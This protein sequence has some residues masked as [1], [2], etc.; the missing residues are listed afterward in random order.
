MYKEDT[1]SVE[2]HERDYIPSLRAMCQSNTVTIA[3]DGGFKKEGSVGSSAAVLLL[4]ASNN[5]GIQ[6][7]YN[8]EVEVG[9][10]N[11]RAELQAMIL[12]LELA[13]DYLRANEL[14]ETESINFILDSSYVRDGM[15]GKWFNIWT[16][17]GWK[18]SEGVEVK[19][20]DLWEKIKRSYEALEALI[21]DPENITFIKIKSHIN[22]SPKALKSHEKGT[23]SF[24]KHN[25]V[26]VTKER[27]LSFVLLNEIADELCTTVKESI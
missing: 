6:Y 16:S 14:L 27:L 19:N 17:N 7:K 5:T 22:R 26:A 11:Q 18:T 3:C 2:Q 23:N 25:G 9:S 4:A 13:Y 10:T 8:T 21:E 1:Y 24:K 20:R 15:L 12:G